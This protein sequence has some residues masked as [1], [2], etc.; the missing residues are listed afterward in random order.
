MKRYFLTLEKG[1][2]QTWI[3]PLTDTT[4]IGRSPDS[5]I[6]LQSPMV[7]RSHARI[8]LQDEVWILED[9]G[10]TNGVFVGGKRVEKVTLKPGDTFKIGDTTFRFQ[11]KEISG[12]SDLLADTVEILSASIEEFGGPS[13]EDQ[14]RSNPERLKKTIAAIPFFS[15]LPESELQKLAD[16]ASLH[17]YN[18]GEVIIREGEP[19]RSVYL[20]LHGRVR[21]FTRDHKGREVDLA[22][23][24]SGEFFG[25]ISFLTGKPRSNHVAAL[26][27]SVVVE[28]SYT[29][30]ARVVRQDSQVRKTL[31]EYYQNRLKSTLKRRAE[32]GMPERRSQP[33]LKE[34]LMTYFTI[35]GEAS[36]ADMYEAATRD[37]SLSGA[38]L[39]FAGPV[40]GCLSE[41]ARLRLEIFLP[42]AQARF[43]TMGVVRR[44]QTS[45]QQAQNALGVQFVETAP[46][47]VQKLKQFI[48]GE[49]PI[50]ADGPEK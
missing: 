50:Q 35:T 16:T 40:P 45:G 44:V 38:E 31:V 32:V 20:V 27:A 48:Y 43:L 33:R 11:E 37:I 3:Y 1:A 28:L 30:M 7:S 8:M 17:V 24:S 6:H 23:L 13:E 42:P 15:S 12:Q 21:A 5:T 2:V 49:G 25:E 29:A 4:T 26:E 36:A 19:G 47:E 14:P 41:G 34:Q 39:A 9:V 18:P 22:T 46:E 10:S